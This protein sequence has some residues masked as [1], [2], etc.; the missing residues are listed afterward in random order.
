MR[1]GKPH[2]K[3]RLYSSGK[4]C[5]RSS[6]RVKCTKGQG[7]C[8]SDAACAGSYVCGVDNCYQFARGRCHKEDDMC[9]TKSKKRADCRRMKRQGRNMCRCGKKSDCRNDN[10]NMNDEESV[11]VGESLLGTITLNS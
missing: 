7:D 11:E 3:G 2:C 8:D 9:T 6:D 1:H 4:D 10:W 5:C